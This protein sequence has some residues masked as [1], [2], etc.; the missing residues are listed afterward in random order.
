MFYNF[1]KKKL[2]KFFKYSFKTFAWE[3]FLIS[4]HTFQTQFQN[5]PQKKIY[6]TFLKNPWHFSAPSWIIFPEKKIIFFPWKPNP[7]RIFSI[8]LKETL[9]QFG[10]TADEVTHTHTKKKSRK[11]KQSKKISFTLGWLL[12]NCKIEK[13]MYSRM[14]AN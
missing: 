2:S 14:T 5:F 12:I 13:N 3:I 8:F 11:T 1:S 10:M 4:W 9:P 6:C 7:S